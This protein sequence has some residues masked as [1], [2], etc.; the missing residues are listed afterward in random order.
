MPLRVQEIGCCLMVFEWKEISNHPNKGVAAIPSRGAKNVLQGF[1]LTIA[2]A[3]SKPL[4][5]D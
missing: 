3:D 4:A 2:L 1:Q 5:G